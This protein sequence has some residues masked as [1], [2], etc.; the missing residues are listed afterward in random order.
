MVQSTAHASLNVSNKLKTRSWKGF[1]RVCTKYSKLWPQATFR[2]TPTPQDKKNKTSK[3]AKLT[4]GVLISHPPRRIYFY[5][6]VSPVYFT[7]C[8][9]FELM[10]CFG[11]RTPPF[12]IFFFPFV[13]YYFS[14]CIMYEILSS[15]NPWKALV[16][17]VIPWDSI[18]W[19][20]NLW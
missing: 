8:N 11:F 17:I 1:G 2:G 19:V 3:Q 12:G 7:V 16:N 5:P 20:F 4:G 10:P 14:A 15:S 18:V 9:T 13:E 6:T